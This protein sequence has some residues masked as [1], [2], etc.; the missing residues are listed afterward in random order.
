MFGGSKQPINPLR[1]RL[2]LNEDTAE[3]C[4]RLAGWW[5]CC[6]NSD[7][8]DVDDDDDEV[9]EDSVPVKGGDGDGE[10]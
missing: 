9:L 8:D 5:R 4:E 2:N 1:C 3:A 10:S 6:S 7:D